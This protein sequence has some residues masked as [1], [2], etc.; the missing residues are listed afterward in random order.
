VAP[1]THP[2]EIENIRKLQT[3]ENF[4]PGIHHGSHPQCLSC[5]YGK[6]TCSPFQKV[7]NLP[8]NI[9]DII[10]SDLCGP[11][12]ASV[13]NFRYLLRPVLQ[14]RT[15][16][17]NSVSQVFLVYFGNPFGLSDLRILPCIPLVVSFPLSVLVM[18]PPVPDSLSLCYKNPQ[19]TCI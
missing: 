3:A 7:E 18:C 2:H 16:S 4:Q 13:G 11:F 5:P 15:H 14:T 19:K 17:W 8:E 10:V 1:Q 6:H 12:E 9:G